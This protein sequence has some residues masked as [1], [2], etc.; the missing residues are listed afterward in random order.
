MKNHI[1]M[2]KMKKN[3]FSV[4]TELTQVYAYRIREY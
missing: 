2:S 1:K 4:N 3:K